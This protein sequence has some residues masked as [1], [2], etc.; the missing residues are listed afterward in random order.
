MSRRQTLSVRECLAPCQR[1]SGAVSNLT[2]GLSNSRNAKCPISR[3]RVLLSGH[4]GHCC[5]V[6]TRAAYAPGTNCTIPGVA[7]NQNWGCSPP[8]PRAG[9]L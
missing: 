3:N 2:L 4:D 8:P 6:P 9:N 7:A 5:S 1:V